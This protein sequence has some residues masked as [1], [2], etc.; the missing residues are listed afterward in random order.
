MKLRFTL[1]LLSTIAVLQ[2][3]AQSWVYDSVALGAGNANDV[4]Y[5]MKNGAI[6]TES[7]T[8]W[9]LGFEMMPPGPY[10]NVSVIANHTLGKVMVYS[11]HSSASA[12]FATFSGSDTTGLIADVNALYNADTNWHYGAFNRTAGSSLLDYGWGMYD[13]TS[14]NVVGDSIFVV[15]VD[16][17]AY[18]LWIKEYVASPSDSVKYT[19]RIA[20]LD[21]SSDN[22]LS[23]YRK[24]YQDKNFVYYDVKNNS[25][26]DRDPA[27]TTWDILFKNYS[28]LTPFG[29][30]VFV[31]YGVTGALSNFGVSVSDVRGVHV[32]SAKYLNYTSAETNYR[33]EIGSDWKTYDMTNMVYVVPDSVSFFVRSFNSSEYYQ[34]RFI[35]YTGSSTGKIHFGKRMVADVT[36]VADVTNNVSAHAIVPNPARN[37]A[38]LMIDAKEAA[39]ARLFVTDITGKVVLNSVVNLNIGMNGLRIDVSGYTSGT[40]LVTLT[41]GSWK[42]TDKLIVQ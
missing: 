6:K 32:D 25:I 27:R 26:V 4:Y 17:D 39:T 7:N 1:L 13:M 20:A 16:G 2:T 3:N 22:T 35:S 41:D 19:F 15:I 33:N 28:E 9:H 5:S 21:G 18:K 14:H 24:P 10:G 38:D 40:Y 37:N 29:P 42:I 11:A 31:N 36:S 34:L 12:N 23:I 30:G 8:N